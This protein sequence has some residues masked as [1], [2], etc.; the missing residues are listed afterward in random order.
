MPEPG[1]LAGAGAEIFTGS[2]SYSYSTSLQYLK[3]FVFTGPKY[4]YKYRKANDTHL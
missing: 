3:Y 1:F 2:G 4:D